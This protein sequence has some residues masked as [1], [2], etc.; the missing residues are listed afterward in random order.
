MGSDVDTDIIILDWNRPDDTIKAVQSALEQTGVQRKIWIVDQGSEPENR[1]KVA[2]FCR[3]H[4]DV[5]IH[6]LDRNVG[7]AAGR[8]IATRLGSAPYVVSLDNDAVFSDS[9]CVARAIAHLE[10]DSQLAA[11]AFRILDADTGTE[12]QHWDYPDEYLHA[13]LDSFEVTR[14]LGGGYALR[15]DA[16]ELAGGY[17][18]RLF[19]CGEERDLGWRL[20]KHGYVLKWQRDLAILHRSTADAKVAWSDRRYYFVVRNALYI[21]HKFGA[22]PFRFARSVGSL[23]VRGVRNG[24]APAAVRGIAEGCVLSLQF[25]FGDPERREMYRLT[26]EVR[27]YIDDIEHKTHET[28]L[29]KLVRQLTLLPK[30]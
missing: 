24:L 4:A 26:P 17:D 20:I 11:V 19:F 27:R 15:R 9:E 10:R 12:D 2:A 14:F 8:N 7:V 16:F 21:N 1:A 28:V 13:G 25:S 18:D 5:H 6:N 22:G 3:D 23:F 30:V 29:Q